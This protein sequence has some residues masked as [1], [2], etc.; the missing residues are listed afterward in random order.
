M[1]NQHTRLAGYLRECRRMG[2][3]ARKLRMRGSSLSDPA[4]RAFYLGEA[5][6]AAQ[7]ADEFREGIEIE[8]ECILLDRQKSASPE[9]R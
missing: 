2:R 5:A 8:I 3:V 6:Q 4:K 9:A 1:T 7:M